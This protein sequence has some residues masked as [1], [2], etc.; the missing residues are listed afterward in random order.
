[1]SKQLSG[2]YS[3]NKID[4]VESS[5]PASSPDGRAFY[6]FTDYTATVFQRVD[7]I[8]FWKLGHWLASKISA[9]LQ[10]SLMR[11][12][13]RLQSRDG[14]RPGCLPGPGQ[15]RSLPRNHTAATGDQPEGSFHLAHCRKAIRTSCAMR[16]RNTFE[17]R[18]ADLVFA[19][20]NT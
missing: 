13:V 20:S 7:R 18:Y 8:V 1:M 11:D 15:S 10:N 4:L 16:S 2:N 17:S 9:S 12:H 19:M 3:M 5:E 6:R 14:P